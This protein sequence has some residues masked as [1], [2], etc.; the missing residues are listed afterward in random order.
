MFIEP[1]ISTKSLVKM[2]MEQSD[3]R[4][5]HEVI[6]VMSQWNGD[7]KR[8]ALEVSLRIGDLEWHI[9]DLMDP[10][11]ADDIS[12]TGV[13]LYRLYENK[14]VAE[15][16]YDTFEKLG[17]MTRESMRHGPEDTIPKFGEI[18]LEKLMEFHQIVDYGGRPCSPPLV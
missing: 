6:S 17:V 18:W 7:P 4:L 10:G 5:A 16:G 12:M 11:S 13:A 3:S 1:Y 14:F 2:G 15:P 9:M 8:R